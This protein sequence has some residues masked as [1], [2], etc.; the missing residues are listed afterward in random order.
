MPF[1][2]N[3][4]DRC[5]FFIHKLMSLVNDLTTQDICS[6]SPNGD[7]FLIYNKDMFM[8]E[9]LPNYFKH[10]NFRS[11]ARQLNLYGFRKVFGFKLIEY[12]HPYF[13]RDR[14]DLYK[15][16]SRRITKSSTSTLSPD[17]NLKYILSSTTD[18][19]S[20]EYL[21]DGGGQKQKQIKN[22][23][24]QEELCHQHC[25]H[26]ISHTSSSMGG[27][28]GLGNDILM[29]RPR[30]IF[31]SQQQVLSQTL[32]IYSPDSSSYS[33]SSS[34]SMTKIESHLSI[35]DKMMK[36]LH[37][38]DEKRQNIITSTTTTTTN[39]TTKEMKKKRNT[40]ITKTKKVKLKQK[41]NNDHKF[42]ENKQLNNNI[43]MIK[44][45]NKN[46]N[47]QQNEAY[48]INI[49]H[50]NNNNNDDFLL[51]GKNKELMVSTFDFP[52]N[53]CLLAGD[54]KKL[55]DEVHDGKVHSDEVSDDAFVDELY[56]DYLPVLLPPPP[57]PLI[58]NVS[59]DSISASI[60]DDIDESSSVITSQ[61][62]N[63][64][65][66]KGEKSLI[67]EDEN[68]TDEKNNDVNENLINTPEIDVKKVKVK[69]NKIFD[70]YND[71]ENGDDVVFKEMAS[72][73]YGHSCMKEYQ[74]LFEQLFKSVLSQN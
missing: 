24:E 19:Y 4:R 57:P 10:D 33:S 30:P 15:F 62:M 12:Q 18:S 16:I 45:I 14:R 9:V 22:N 54:T 2:N 69:N 35:F 49:Y 38:K 74:P 28:M 56:L 65:Y 23:K 7:S 1:C 32:P 27:S 59:D 46:D 17:H 34:S 3:K 31:Q 52:D 20:E 58:H 43:N 48:N 41:D 72:F 29:I 68:K 53:N 39:A 26:S 66:D 73:M 51:D 5:A 25:P 47:E 21:R 42:Y 63:A 8:A 44:N 50:N 13:L 55:H 36:E 70:G 61:M 71:N 11:F 6:F 40:K 64:L 37:K 60:I 67:A